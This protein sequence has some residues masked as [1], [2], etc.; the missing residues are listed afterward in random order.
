MSEWRKSLRL[1]THTWTFTY[2]EAKQHQVAT[3]F[4]DLSINL[5]SLF[6]FKIYADAS[7]TVLGDKE[8]QN[9]PYLKAAASRC[10]TLFLE[11]VKLLQL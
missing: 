4:S 10:L 5:P 1:H 11:N 8:Q 9:L 3:S 6:I 2:I 7:L